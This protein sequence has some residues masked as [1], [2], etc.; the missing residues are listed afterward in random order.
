[1]GRNGTKEK[2]LILAKFVEG[3]TKLLSR[4]FVTIKVT[5][6]KPDPENPEKE[7]EKET[8]YQLPIKSIGMVEFQ[9]ALKRNAPVPPSKLTKVKKGSELETEYGLEEGS[10]VRIYD[11]TDEEFLKKFEEYKNE[12]YWQLVIEALDV[13]FVDKDGNEITDYNKIKEILSNSGITG[14]HLDRIVEAVNR[15]TS[16]R[17]ERADFLSG[18]LW[19]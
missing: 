13:S 4:G 8:Y 9:E 15:L 11:V 19:G 14:H 3:K 2:P 1:M 17:E 5:E 12:F 16:D 10:L 6:R 7:V 18:K